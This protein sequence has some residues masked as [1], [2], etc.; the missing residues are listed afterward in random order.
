MAL[1]PLALD[2]GEQELAALHAQVL[3]GP[4]EIETDSVELAYSV[5]GYSVGAVEQSDAVRFHIAGLVVNDLNQ[6]ELGWRLTAHPEPLVNG[7]H[8]LPLGNY[9]GFTGFAERADLYSPSRDELVFLSGQGVAGLVTDYDVAFTIPAFA[10]A[11][12]YSGIVTFSIVA[13]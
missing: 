2:A 7:D 10:P 12:T 4:L 11:G 1:S 3:P 6:D 13:E 5:S 9:T 8:A